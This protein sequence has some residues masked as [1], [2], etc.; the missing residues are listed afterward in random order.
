LR[1]RD[2][3]KPNSRG[4]RKAKHIFSFEVEAILFV[5]HALQAPGA[6]PIVGPW[7]GFNAMLGYEFWFDYFRNVRSRS[8]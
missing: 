1:K 3:L 2:D 8:S 5:R 4:I 6:Q 7:L